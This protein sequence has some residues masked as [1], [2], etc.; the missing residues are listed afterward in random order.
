MEKITVPAKLN[1]IQAVRSLLYV[2]VYLALAKLEAQGITLNICNPHDDKGNEIVGDAEAFREFMNRDDLHFCICDPMMVPINEPLLNSNAVIVGTLINKAAL[3][4]MT[5]NE[6]LY[7]RL[8]GEDPKSN[9]FTAPWIAGKNVVSYSRPSTAGAIIAFHHQKSSKNHGSFEMY[10]VENGLEL[11]YLDTALRGKFMDIVITADLLAYEAHYNYNSDARD[12]HTFV[13]DW[14]SFFF[15]GIITKRAMLVQENLTYVKLLLSAI[16]QS[17]IELYDYTLRNTPPPIKFIDH[18]MQNLDKYTRFQ[19]HPIFEG[20]ELDNRLIVERALDLYLKL[21]IPSKTISVDFRAFETAFKLRT[22]INSI[23]GSS[24]KYYNNLVDNRIANILDRRYR[25]PLIRRMVWF[26]YSNI[27][28]P[29]KRFWS[30]AVPSILAILFH[31]VAKASLYTIIF[32]LGVIILFSIFFDR[33]IK[34]FEA[35]FHQNSNEIKEI[36][37]D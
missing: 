9:I 15:T 8:T 12:I 36:S 32:W 28:L 19:C 34:W 5:K 4:A 10:S 23:K 11:T 22:S 18:L 30:F 33:F 25:E 17:T 27:V 6:N 21:E 13:N 31:L 16:K 24:K 26:I 29:Y 2:P 37:N 20:V 14:D 7:Y 35:H 1:L 3:W